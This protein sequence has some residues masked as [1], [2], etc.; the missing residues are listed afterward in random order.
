MGSVV[1]KRQGY[2]GSK[3]ILDPKKVHLPGSIPTTHKTSRVAWPP[4]GH[5]ASVYVRPH[6]SPGS[7]SP[8]HYSQ[9]R[10]SIHL[11]SLCVSK[12]VMWESSGWLD[13]LERC[14]L[15]RSKHERQLI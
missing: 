7:E 10:G 13:L 12:Q 15:S 14:Y 11:L 6:R 9:R 1:G 8:G 4:R 5:S 3:D 2:F